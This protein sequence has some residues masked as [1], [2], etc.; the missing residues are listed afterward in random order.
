MALKY[1]VLPSAS[2]P[3]FPRKPDYNIFSEV[4]MSR[5]FPFVTFVAIAITTPVWGQT[6][7]DVTVQVG[8]IPSHRGE[9]PCVGR[10]MPVETGSA[11]ADYD[12]DDDLD[13]FVTNGDGPSRFYR[14][15]GDTNGDELPDFI[16]IGIGLNMHDSTLIGH[17]ANFIDYDNDGDQDLF[18]TFWGEQKMY[19][20]QLS[21]G[22][23]PLF[24]DV[25]AAAG[26]TDDGRTITSVWGDFDQDGHNDLYLVK[27]N[28][29]DDDPRNDDQLLRNNGDGTFTDVSGWL[30]P[31]GV[32]PCEQLEGAGF[33]ASWFD[34]DNDADPDLYVANKFPASTLR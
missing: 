11:W 18:V 10:Y 22:G 27:Q 13:F 9:A 3:F 31:G 21:D 30:C 32:A 19:Q 20:N 5:L 25:T 24:I 28:Y 34:Y 8:I 15:D 4:T 17:S 2:P 16:E 23:G 26:L 12:N 6:F 14:N 1:S 7:S 29:C 33:S